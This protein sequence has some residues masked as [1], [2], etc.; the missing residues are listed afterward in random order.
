M[1]QSFCTSLLERKKPNAIN[2]SPRRKDE[3][4]VIN[5]LRL[6]FPL[7]KTN[8]ALHFHSSPT[9]PA[10]KRATSPEPPLPWCRPAA[11]GPQQLPRKHLA[12]GK[13]LHSTKQSYF[14]K[15]PFVDGL[16]QSL[17]TH[18]QPRNLS[19]TTGVRFKVGIYIHNPDPTVQWP[20][21]IN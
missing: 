21:N 2:H 14:S 5:Y 18:Q 10:Q 20:E 15:S 1:Q 6:I 9:A 4:S 12:G 17:Q 11:C 13:P 19:W 16:W 7:L 3:I 8:P